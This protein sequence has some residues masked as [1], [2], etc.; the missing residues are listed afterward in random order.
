MNVVS[1]FF[2]LKI[3]EECFKAIFR[4]GSLHLLFENLVLLSEG[5]L[6]RN[7]SRAFDHYLCLLVHV[8]FGG[9]G[10]RGRTACPDAP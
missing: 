10:D 2:I 9:E 3:S 6:E 8:T 4:L 1:N 5:W 7:G